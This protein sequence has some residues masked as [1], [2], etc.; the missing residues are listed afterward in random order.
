VFETFGHGGQAQNLATVPATCPA[1]AICA[2]RIRY[3]TANA[4]DGA[5]NSANPAWA[6]DGSRIAFSEWTVPEDPS[7]G[8]WFA[9]IFTFDPYGRRRQ[10]VSQ[11]PEWSMRPNWTAALRR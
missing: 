11:A 7:T 5:T 3:L 9:G 6:P 10:L 4:P 2:K 8:D 1:L